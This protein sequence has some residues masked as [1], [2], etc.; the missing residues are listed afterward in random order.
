M[1]TIPDSSVLPAGADAVSL[2]SPVAGEH[3]CD[4]AVALMPC[5]GSLI[6]S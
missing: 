4:S 6:K 2:C 3:G 1:V 5:F